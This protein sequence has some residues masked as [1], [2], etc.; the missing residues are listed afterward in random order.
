MK[1]A[2][3]FTGWSDPTRPAQPITR[4]ALARTVRA[5]RA[6]GVQLRRYARHDGHAYVI[7]HPGG[8]SAVAFL[9]EARHAQS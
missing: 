6:M 9:V 5:W 3:Y 4:D 1:R 8:P 2:A 7:T